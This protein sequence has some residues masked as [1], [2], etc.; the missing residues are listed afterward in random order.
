MFLGAFENSLECNYGYVFYFAG[1]GRIYV[2]KL[3][4]WTPDAVSHP[5]YWLCLI[6]IDSESECFQVHSKAL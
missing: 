1:F 6:F 2:E 4:K 5:Q 3:P